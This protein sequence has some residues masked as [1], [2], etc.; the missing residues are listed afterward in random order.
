MKDCPKGTRI[1]LNCY[2]PRWKEG[3]PYNVRLLHE[4][5]DDDEFG[6]WSNG[7]VDE[8]RDLKEQQRVRLCPETIQKRYREARCYTFLYEGDYNK[9][10]R[11][12]NKING[13][14]GTVNRL[15]PS[16]DPAQIGVYWDQG[17]NES[18][19]WTDFDKLEVI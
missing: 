18:F 11:I 16:Y 17:C 14:T 2:P 6:W 7:F 10:D 1:Y 19:Y 5:L 15:F 13:N 12:K 8:T 4:K 9:K 3:E